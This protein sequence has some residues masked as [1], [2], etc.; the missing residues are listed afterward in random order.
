ML[1]RIYILLLAVLTVV[2]VTGCSKDDSQ[3]V[4]SELQKEEQNE[5]KMDVKEL[6]FEHLGD[7]YGWEVPFSHTVR[8]PLPVIV[9]AEDHSWFCFSS[10]DL[11]LSLIHI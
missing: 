6:I 8:M 4:S 10:A 2:M 7:G 1:K 11:T 9:R 5:E 3:K